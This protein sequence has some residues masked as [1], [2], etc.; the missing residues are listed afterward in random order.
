MR[1]KNTSHGASAA[2]KPDPAN[3]SST[4]FSSASGA[5][6]GGWTGWGNLT[7]S[8]FSTSGNTLLTIGTGKTDVNYNP[9]RYYAI[10]DIAEVEV[11]KIKNV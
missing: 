11:T 1:R 7:V 2:I 4:A 8:N 10:W 9:Y 3:F 6:Q 5:V